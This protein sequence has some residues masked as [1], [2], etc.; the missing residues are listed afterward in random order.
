MA[1]SF[2]WLVFLFALSVS[3]LAAGRP[4]LAAPAGVT[5]ADLRCEYL[6][7]PVGI[8]EPAPRLFWRLAGSA[9][10][11]RQAAYQVL[12]ASTAGGAHAMGLDGQIGTIEKG[13]AADLLVVA[14]DPSADIR[15][16]RQVRKVMRGGVLHAVSE[17]ATPR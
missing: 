9:R 1:R 5:P 6:V 12:V 14:A 4:A 17:L 16:L 8:D 2:R 15:N 13:K 7:N 11:Q 10:G 3:G